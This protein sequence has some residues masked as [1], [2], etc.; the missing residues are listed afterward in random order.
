MTEQQLRDVLAR[1][2][3]EAPDTVADPAPVVRAARRQRNLRVIGTGA[4]AA[5]LVAGTAFGVQ[6]LTSDDKD[7]VA[8]GPLFPDPYTAAQCPDLPADQL[9]NSSL[10]DLDQVV[11]VRYCTRDAGSGFPA[12]QGPVDALV[13]D[14]GTFTEGIRSLA[15]ADASRCAA[16]DPIPT[17]SRL[18]LELAD[19]SY[20]TVPAGLC[21]DAD[22]EG[23]P[24][25]GADA[26]QAFLEALRGQRDGRSY[27]PD[28]VV[29][30]TDCRASGISPAAPTSESLVSGISC[31]G[32]GTL[33]ATEMTPE[34]LAQLDEAW[35]TATDGTPN[36]DETGDLGL[37]TI[38]ARTDRGDLVRLDPMGCGQYTYFSST[39]EEYLVTF[40][41]EDN[42]GSGS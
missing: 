27:A 32:S 11:A 31:V 20:V 33:T 21:Q 23:R 8:Q 42:T 26:T 30:P 34:E 16:V 9:V 24:I 1:V 14:I 41:Y 36:C 5:V 7:L 10:T 38:L 29:L 22:F 37:T 25:D 15:P 2:V 35:R 19:G 3:P 12:A 6:S 40:T 17:D 28:E 4:V 13:D 39:Q 18:H